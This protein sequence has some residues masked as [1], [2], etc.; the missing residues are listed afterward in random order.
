M[1][2]QRN[3]DDLLA[4][5]GRYAT[6]R[7]APVATIV[8][9]ILHYEILYA[10]LQSNAIPKLTFQGGTALRLCYR[11]TRYSEDLDFAGGNEFDPGVMASFADFLKHGIGEAYGLEVDIREPKATG[12]AKGVSVKRWNARVH[13]PQV[14]RNAVQK[15]VI[16]IEVASVPAYEPDLM[17]VQMNYAHLPHNF[18]QMLIPVE[19]LTEILADKI[20]ALGARDHFKARDIWDI[21]FLLDLSVPP[22]DTL[23]L[24]SKKLV[25]YGWTEKAFKNKLSMRIAQLGEPETMQAFHQ[26]MSRFVDGTVASQLAAPLIAARYL[27][28]SADLGKQMLDADLTPSGPLPG[29]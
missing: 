22:H 16:N 7:R 19:T 20:V 8:K 18:A 10:L 9:E 3:R 1:T 23:P 17:P 6:E 15:Q 12:P 28:R 11:G 13:V 29:R 21:K 26:E 2:M 4:L 25:D 14:N 5:A 27:Q 24:V